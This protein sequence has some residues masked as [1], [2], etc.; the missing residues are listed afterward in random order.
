MVW[1]FI[2][3]NFNDVLT[4]HPKDSPTNIFKMPKL[5]LRGFNRE[6]LK[7]ITFGFIVRN[8]LESNYF[9]L[10]NCNI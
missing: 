3:R 7:I 5:L 10:I 8:I 2:G 9:I 6:V 4:C 1:S